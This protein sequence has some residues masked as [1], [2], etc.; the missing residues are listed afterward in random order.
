M[1]LAGDWRRTYAAHPDHGQRTTCL[2]RSTTEVRTGSEW[3]AHTLQVLTLQ[4]GAIAALTVFRDPQLFV[5][6]GFPVVLP[7]Q[8]AGASA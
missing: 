4:D 2:L 7:Y 5:A 8:V 1:G 6:F 3:H